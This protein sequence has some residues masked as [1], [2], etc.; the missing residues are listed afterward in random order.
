MNYSALVNKMIVLFLTLAVGYFAA[1]RR[2]MNEDTNRHLSKLL[3]NITNPLL[4]LASVLTGTHPLTNLQVLLLTLTAACG[5]FVL[6]ALSFFLPKLLRVPPDKAGT[7]RFLL[8]FSNVGFVGYPIVQALFGDGAMFYVTIYVMAFQLFV[9]SY[10]VHLIAD[11]EAKFQ[12][13][14]DILKRPCFIA[15]ILAYILYF[16][17]LQLPAVIGQAASYVGDLTSPISMLIIGCALA[18]MPLRRVFS[19]WRLYVLA[20]V[21]MIVIPTAAY[22]ALRLVFRDQLMLGIA[23]IMLCMPSATNTAIISYEYGGDGELASSGVF[24]TT[25]LSV[26]S[27]PALMYLLFR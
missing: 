20:A 2:L 21:K 24:L 3:V 9:W 16:T 10:G 15:S 27:I 5:Y 25:L 6:I 14:W 12:F 18:Q 26:V 11:P 1:R 7:Y 17:R 22:F 4:I 8:I 23:V 13:K 19:S